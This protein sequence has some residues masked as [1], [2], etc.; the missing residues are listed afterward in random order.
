[1]IISFVYHAGIRSLLILARETE[2][3][4]SVE[5]KTDCDASPETSDFQ[6]IVGNEET[7]WLS[8]HKKYNWVFVLLFILLLLT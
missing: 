8:L 3:D 6:S 7:K 5:G 1:M 2:L 4:G